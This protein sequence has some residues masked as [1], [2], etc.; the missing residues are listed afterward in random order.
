MNP[1]GATGAQPES[2]AAAGPADRA[3]PAPEVLATP[4]PAHIPPTD[5]APPALGQPS[6]P[7]HRPGM[8]WL[9]ALPLL[10]RPITRTMPW[11]TLITGCLAGTAFLA[12]MARVAGTSHSPLDLGTARLAFLPAIAALAFILRTPFRPLTQVTPVPAWLAPA[13]HIVLAAPVLAVTCWAQLRIVAHTI[14]PHALS[15]P[16]AIYPVIAQ[17]TGWCAVTVAAAAC[18]DRSRYADLGGAIAAP[19]SFAAIALAW[20]A[21]VT[22]R[23]L[24]EPPATAHVVTIAWYC[25]ATAGLALSCAAMRDR[26]HRYMRNLHRLPGPQRNS[27]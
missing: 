2:S 22:G 9:R 1:P 16:P 20:H 3:K 18:A 23:F 11:A 15:H 14:P 25:I 24:I 26:W 21:P 7:A 8:S 10:A 6:R 5:G 13:G 17:L 27:P 19:V 12:V 4:R